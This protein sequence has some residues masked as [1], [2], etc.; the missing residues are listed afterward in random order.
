MSRSKTYQ[1]QIDEKDKN[2]TFAIFNDLGI[3]PAQAVKMFF[4]QV[5]RTR[6]IPFPIEDT[7]NEKVSKILLEDRKYSKSFKNVDDLFSDLET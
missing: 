3:T 6:K 5:R 1:I 4:A 2:E 7:P